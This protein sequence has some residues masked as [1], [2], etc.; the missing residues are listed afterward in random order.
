MNETRITLHRSV[1]E[2][3]EIALRQLTSPQG[4][5]HYEVVVNGTSLF[6]T[7]NRDS[8]RALARLAVYPVLTLRRPLHVLI[9]GLGIG[10]T[11]GAVLE[12]KEVCSVTVVEKE[13]TVVDWYKTYFGPYNGKSIEDPRVSIVVGDFLSFIR[14]TRIAYDSMC[15]DLDNGPDWLVWEENRVLYEESGLNQIKNVMKSGGCLGIWS[16]SR[17][18]LFED[19]LRRIFKN[20]SVH[21]INTT[22]MGKEVE[23][24]IYTA[25]RQHR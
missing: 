22:E 5:L 14:N 9:G 8:E 15:L 17:A 10:Y 7:Y 24:H 25:T 20:A 21:T 23:Y 3:G 1:T 4:N 13:K 2:D 11:L 12:Y 6:S 16:S 18:D 19:R